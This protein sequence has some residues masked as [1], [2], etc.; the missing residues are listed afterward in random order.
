MTSGI[1]AINDVDRGLPIYVGRSKHIERRIKQHEKDWWRAE[2]NAVRSGWLSAPFIRSKRSVFAL[3]SIEGR[4]FD[5]NVLDETED[6]LE[7]AEA[8][9]IDHYVSSGVPLANGYATSTYQGRVMKLPCPYSESFGISPTALCLE[10]KVSIHQTYLL[11]RLKRDKPELAE[12]VVTGELSAS[13]AA[14]AAGIRK[15]TWTAPDDPERLAARV[16]QRYPGWAMVRVDSGNPE[17]AA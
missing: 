5:W 15:P 1:Y 17:E 4:P 10:H 16:R 13:A 12:K 2:R 8:F 3:L 11:K 14:V 6:D 7:R 9:W